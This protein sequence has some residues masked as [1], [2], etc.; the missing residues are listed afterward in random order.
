[1]KAAAATAAAKKPQTTI[2]NLI[3]QYAKQPPQIGDESISNS[4]FG[5]LLQIIE[6]YN[7]IMPVFK[8][9]LSQTDVGYKKLKY[10]L[11]LK[12]LLSDC[13]DSVGEAS[14]DAARLY[15][16][17]TVKRFLM[18]FIYYKKI[19]PVSDLKAYLASEKVK[20]I[21]RL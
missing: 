19:M 2:T 21:L 16:V 8:E 7:M 18:V 20:S 10:E 9:F 4:D 3:K 1:M 6:Q 17:N 13:S 12:S 15:Y 11:L 5:D 14:S